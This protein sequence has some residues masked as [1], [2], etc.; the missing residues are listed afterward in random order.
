M[1][2]LDIP[3]PWGAPVYFEDTL[4]STMDLARTLALRG[5]PGGTVIAAAFQEHGRGRVRGRLWRMNRGENLAFTILLPYG[6]PLPEALT[7]RAGLAAARAVEEFAPAL[8]G[9]VMVKW[10]NDVMITSPGTPGARKAGGIL[11]ESDGAFVYLGVGINVG[12]REFPPELEAKA[13]SLALAL[14]E[15]RGPPPASPGALLGL[16]LKQLHGE[17][18][19]PSAPPWREGLES[20]LFGKGT[21]VRF[22]EGPAGSGRPVEGVLRGIGPGGELLIAG[23]GGLRSFITGELDLYYE[24]A[25]CL[26]G[27]PVVR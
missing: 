19:D 27:P 11:G 5:E 15:V 1:K 23:E 17:L 22:I 20:R 3:N 2:V 9:A 8:K 18:E 24:T 6:N 12:Q 16:I 21:R 7:L 25:P 13:V 4:S 26:R 14:E 10:P